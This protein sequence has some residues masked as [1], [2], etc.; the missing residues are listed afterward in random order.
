MS[1]VKLSIKINR[2]NIVLDIW[3]KKGIYQKLIWVSYGL[4]ARS[5]VFTSTQGDDFDLQDGFD[6]R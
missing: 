1:L 4:S 2:H 6:G 3:M 5:F